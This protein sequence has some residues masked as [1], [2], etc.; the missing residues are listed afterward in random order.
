MTRGHP[1][2]LMTRPA[3]PLHFHTAP[4]T[5]HHDVQEIA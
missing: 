2:P 4:F 1:S 5:H 3:A